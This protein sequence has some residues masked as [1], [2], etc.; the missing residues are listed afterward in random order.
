MTKMTYEA[1]ILRAHGKV[2]ALTK[3]GVDGAFTDMMFPSDTPK[4]DLTFS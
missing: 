4:G 3:G 1:P 2:E